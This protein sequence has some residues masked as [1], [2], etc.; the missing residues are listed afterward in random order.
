MEKTIERLKKERNAVILAH[1]YQ[2]PEIIEIADFVGDSLGLSQKAKETTADVIVF[3]GVRF[4]AETAKILNPEKTILLPVADAGCP[5]ADMVDAEAVRELKKQFPGL[6]VACYINTTAEV[7]AECDYCVTSS[8]AK[9]IIGGIDSNKVLFVPDRNL[10]EYVGIQT[11]KNIICSEGFCPIHENI[12]E[13]EL[14]NKIRS[15]MKMGWPII[16]LAHPECNQSILEWADWIGSTEKMLDV[17]KQ[18]VPDTIFIIATEVGLAYRF[19]KANPDTMFMMADDNAVCE[20]MKK[21]RLEDIVNAL[22][23]LETEVFVDEKIA[24]KAKKCIDTMF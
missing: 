19:E 7:K 1:S 9:D 6:P 3:A 15:S 18:H 16:I 17:P 21:T 2:R 14:L 5:M 24:V 11:G 12:R 4:M 13:E 23:N 10:G 20:N 22:E 8:N